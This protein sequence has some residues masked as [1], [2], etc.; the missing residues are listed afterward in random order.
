MS[1]TQSLIPYRDSC[2]IPSFVCIAPPSKPTVSVSP[3]AVTIGRQ[4]NITCDISPVLSGFTYSWT[5]NNSALST[6]SQTIVIASFQEAN[7]GFYT[8][9]VT[10]GTQQNASDPRLV[11][12]ICE[13]L[14]FILFNLLYIGF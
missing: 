11:A 10:F 6:T 3:A 13:S 4:V 2:V 9:V 1:V 14:P 7:V 12:T 8:C 5:F